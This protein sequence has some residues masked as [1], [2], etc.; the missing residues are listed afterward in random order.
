MNSKLDLGLCN[1]PE[2][3]YLYV[4]S[5]GFEGRNYCWYYHNTDTKVNT[6]E[7]ATGVCGYLSEVRVTAK[8]FN[9][10]ETPKL[11]IVISANE[12]Y[13][14]RT[15]ID[16]NYAKGF[17]LAIEL[18]EDLSL[19][20]IIGCSAGEQNTVFC[21]VYDATTKSRFKPAWDSRV[22]CAS[23]IHAV[24]ARLNGK[25]EPMTQSPRPSDRPID[26]RSNS[27]KPI[28]TV[29]P[30]PPPKKTVITPASV[31][32]NTSPVVS[33]QDMRIR[34]I[35]TLL[36]YPT[37]LIIE[38][39]GFQNAEK[40]SDLEPKVVDVLVK[41]MCLAWANDKFDNSTDA[42]KSYEQQVI[43]AVASGAKE[44][45]AIQDWI[46]YIMAPVTKEAVPVRR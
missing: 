40:P 19:P 41:D 43:R 34:E 5:G 44:I 10:R 17:L 39:L 30:P 16:T 8:E 27:Q 25:S 36:G 14:I 4:R 7:Y 29:T 26:V 2:P 45:V 15:G 37:D 22:D 23:I 33:N 28:K 21:Q 20:L 35:R 18:V 11:D 46:S 32:V 12:T 31:P 6:P 3:I 9:G 38:W 42:A 1:I 24:Q 13:I